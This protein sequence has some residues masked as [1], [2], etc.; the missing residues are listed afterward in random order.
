MLKPFYSLEA[1]H[2]LGIPQSARTLKNRM[3]G[4]YIHFGHG[5]PPLKVSKIAGKNVIA[6]ADLYAWLRAMGGLPD[7]AT[8]PTAPTVEQ[9]PTRARRR[10]GRPRK[11]V[12]SGARP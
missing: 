2:E 6:A 9:A 11:A 10:P 5:Q 4:G 3:H 8:A 7:D 12:S 1:L